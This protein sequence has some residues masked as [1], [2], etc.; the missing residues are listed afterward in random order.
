MDEAPDFGPGGCS[1]ML[2]GVHRSQPSAPSSR[3]QAEDVRE[4][5]CAAYAPSNQPSL[6]YQPPL[7]PKWLRI[8]TIRYGIFTV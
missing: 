1:G 5:G 3:P 6:V 7:E 2:V 8:L 4:E